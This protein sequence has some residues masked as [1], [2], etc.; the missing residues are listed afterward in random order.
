MEA[1][2]LCPAGRL[3]GHAQAGEGKSLGGETRA[4]PAFLSSLVLLKLGRLD[5]ASLLVA[6]RLTWWEQGSWISTL[7]QTQ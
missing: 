5:S 7:S 6:G 1:G 2:L 4:P 3:L